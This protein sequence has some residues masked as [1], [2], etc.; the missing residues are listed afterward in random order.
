MS[1][2]LPMK[3]SLIISAVACSMAF[4]ACTKTET[5]VTTVTP[6]PESVVIDTTPAFVRTIDPIALSAALTIGYGGTS[7]KASFPASSA[8]AAAPKLNP[9]YN[10]RTYY[11]VNNRYVV[12]YP[13]T[14]EG[15]IAGYYLTVNGADSYY[16]IDYGVFNEN[17]NQDRKAARSKNTHVNSIRENGGHED[18]AIVIKL[19]ANLKGDT[20]TV[21]YA[22]YDKENRVSNP[23]TAIVSVL[24]SKD[25]TDD[26]KL[27]GNWEIASYKSRNNDWEENYESYY[28]IRTLYC[29]NNLINYWGNGENKGEHTYQ[30]GKST[31]TYSFNA[32]N[33]FTYTSNR[34]DSVLDLTNSTCSDYLF[35]Q[36]YND[37]YTDFGG[38]SYDASTKTIAVIWDYNGSLNADNLYVD[39]YTVKELT[40]TTALIY[41]NDSY[42]SQDQPRLYYYKLIKK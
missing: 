14:T 31:Y 24:A 12:I 17:L 30:K 18:S 36:S 22:A 26:S 20:F 25:A 34:V 19:P 9:D 2:S 8:D 15:F 42:N 6:P 21:K 28:Y 16:K 5:V 40:A 39:R 33:A 23:V 1:I 13:R 27:L 3:Q 11:A 32:N 38:Y 7:T 29:Y 4:Y 41:R 10:G 37:T 35:T